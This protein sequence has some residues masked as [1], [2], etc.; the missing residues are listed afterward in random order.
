MRLCLL[1]TWMCGIAAAQVWSLNAPSN[2]MVGDVVALRVTREGRPVEGVEIRVAGPATRQGSVTAA[3]LNV[4]EGPGTDQPIR[5]VLYRGENVLV[6]SDAGGWC[7]VI[8]SVGRSGFASCEFLDLKPFGQPLAR[9]DADGRVVSR[10][11][12]FAASSLELNVVSDGAAVAQA[13]LTVAP[14]V[15]D[16]TTPIAEGISYRERRWVKGDD[17]PFTMQIVEV[18]PAAP[19]VFLLPV[20]ANDRAITREATSSMSRRFGATAAINAGYFVVTTT[21]TGWSGQSVGDYVWNREMISAGNG[22]TALV[23]CA[24]GSTKRVD[25]DQF[26]YRGRVIAA[27]GTAA[28]LLGL[29]KARATQDLAL[30]RPVFGETTQTNGAGAEAI[31]D[32]QNRVVAVEDARGN[33]AIPRDGAVLSGA[34]AG[35]TFIR[36]RLRP[37]EATQIETALEPVTAGTCSPQDVLG[38]GPRLVSQGQVNVTRENFGHEATR[39]PRTIFAVTERGTWLLA[40]LDGRQPASA[41]MRLDELAEELIALGAVEAMNLDGG[42]SSTMVVNDAVRN[43]PSDGPERPVSDALLVFSVSDLGALFKVLERLVVD[44]K[45]ISPVMAETLYGRYNAAVT[46]QEEGDLD[47][48]RGALDA[49]RKDVEQ[50]GGEIG[51]AAVRALLAAVDAYIALLPKPQN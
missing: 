19:Q 38:G 6:T 11:V 13:T 27:D 5:G 14:F 4:R 32:A 25:I 31:L 1:F 29:N 20:R 48:L 37:G 33:A 10:E 39:N 24:P 46:A 47:A 35:A 51:R 9:T 16:Y 44:E 22:R 43:V 49:W 50:A 28:N 26:R 40:T 21:A 30:F 12:A 34:G 2:V 45:Q 18:D 7:G 41:G 15:Y 42:G 36:E 17:G 23:L 8:N 3:T